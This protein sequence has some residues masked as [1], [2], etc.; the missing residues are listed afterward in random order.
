MCCQL[1]LLTVETFVPFLHVKEDGCRVYSPNRLLFFLNI[2][3]EMF[4][5]LKKQCNMSD[6]LNFFI[7]YCSLGLLELRLWFD[8]RSSILNHLEKYILLF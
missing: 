6:Y 3:R 2:K 4:D 1:M 7:F 8:M 5:K